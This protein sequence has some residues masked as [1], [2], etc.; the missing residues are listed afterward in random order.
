MLSN[1]DALEREDSYVRLGRREGTGKE[2]SF[3]ILLGRRE[4]KIDISRR[5]LSLYWFSIPL[6]NAPFSTSTTKQLYRHHRWSVRR[7]VNSVTKCAV[8]Y[9]QRFILSRDEAALRTTVGRSV[10]QFRYEI[11]HFPFPTFYF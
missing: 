3:Q 1:S 9:F 8:F 6:R 11:H 4:L 10:R 7:F 5:C 2:E